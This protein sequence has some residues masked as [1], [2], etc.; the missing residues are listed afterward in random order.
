M[1]CIPRGRHS[2]KNELL[3]ETTLVLAIP[4]LS[5]VE[6]RQDIRLAN[7]RGALIVSQIVGNV[8]N[9]P[10]YHQTQLSG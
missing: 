9:P 2:S 10:L 4:R 5:V 6:D 8:A 7:L 1:S 3:D